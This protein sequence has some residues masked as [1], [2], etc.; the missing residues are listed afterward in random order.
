MGLDDFVSKNKFGLLGL[1][2]GFPGVLTGHLIDESVNAADDYPGYQSS[3]LSPETQQA[4]DEYQSRAQA[5]PEQIQAQNLKG[6]EGAGREL[7]GGKDQTTA[8]LGGDQE[9]G[10]L[11]EA[12]KRRSE[13]IYGGGV[14]NV[15]RQAQLDA[16]IT[17]SKRLTNAF[18]MRGAE[19]QF[20]MANYQRQYAAWL[21]KQNAR[22]EVLKSVF[23]TGGKIVGMA[24]AGPPGAEVANEATAPEGYADQV[25][26]GQDQSYMPGYGPNSSSMNGF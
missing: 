16:P 5:T 2:A 3:Q 26:Q 6:V 10:A 15:K 21:S 1:P 23:S 11:A 17:S 4:M 24:V 19:M 13:Q 20:Q 7:M 8:S 18:G 22:N 9:S 25:L 14:A 12:L